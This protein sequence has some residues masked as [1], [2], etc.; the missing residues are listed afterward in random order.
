MTP[1]GLRGS[2]PNS[3]RLKATRV[4]TG[5]TRNGKSFQ[6]SDNWKDPQCSHRQLDFEWVG[7]TAFEEKGT[8]NLISRLADTELKKEAVAS[9]GEIVGV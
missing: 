5:R 8:G 7:T 2:P 9:K 1:Y 4:T 3:V 6:I